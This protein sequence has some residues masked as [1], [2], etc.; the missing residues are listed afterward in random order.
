[1]GGEG[2]QWAG[3]GRSINADER[4]L[5]G[6]ATL[7]QRAPQ[8]RGAGGTRRDRA[9]RAAPDSSAGDGPVARTRVT[10]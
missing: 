1:M 4:G 8:T 3:G 2:R 10:P 6:R 9:P 5:D 7:H